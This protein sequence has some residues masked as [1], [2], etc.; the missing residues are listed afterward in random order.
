MHDPCSSQR[1]KASLVPTLMPMLTHSA[2]RMLRTREVSPSPMSLASQH[3]Q[4]KLY[5]TPLVGTMMLS[6]SIS[7]QLSGVAPSCPTWE[8][9]RENSSWGKGIALHG[10]GSPGNEGLRACLH[11]H[12]KPFFRGVE[13]TLKQC[14]CHGQGT[15]NWA[16]LYENMPSLLSLCSCAVNPSMLICRGQ[17]T[18]FSTFTGPS[19]SATALG[20]DY[21]KLYSQEERCSANTHMHYY[22]HFP[23]KSTYK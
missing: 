6:S 16:E 13:A 14:H 8:G 4:A 12:N 1:H 9:Q 3:L 23:H 10:G 19:T 21:S 20:S 15:Q 5:M 11:H 18:Q 22:K 7:Q 2:S 17:Q